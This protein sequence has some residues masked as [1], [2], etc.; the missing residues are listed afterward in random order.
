VFET[1]SESP[2]VNCE[3]SGKDM[4]GAET[5]MYQ[6]RYINVSRPL[7]AANYTCDK[8]SQLS[9]SWISILEWMAQRNLYKYYRLASTHPIGMGCVEWN[10]ES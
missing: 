9:T 10:P 6:T 3:R 7:I 4:P 2:G 1:M 8:Y 5:S